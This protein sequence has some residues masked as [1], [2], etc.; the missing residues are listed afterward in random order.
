MVEK[1]NLSNRV[2]HRLEL[3]P[4]DHD[5]FHGDKD[6]SFLPENVPIDGR[7]IETSEFGYERR[8]HRRRAWK[9]IRP[10]GQS[11]ILSR[12]WDGYLRQMP[13]SLTPL[14]GNVDT[15][16]LF[17]L[18][19]AAR[20]NHVVEH[21]EVTTSRDNILSQTPR[22]QYFVHPHRHRYQFIQDPVFSEISPLLVY[23]T[24]ER[25]WAGA[26]PKAE[27]EVN[28]EIVSGVEPI[29]RR[30]LRVGELRFRHGRRP[31]HEESQLLESERLQEHKGR[32]LGTARKFGPARDIGNKL[33]ASLGL[34]PLPAIVGIVDG[35]PLQEERRNHRRGYMRGPE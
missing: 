3:F 19:V 33:H 22:Y 35:A 29:E 23:R 17:S 14:L 12:R 11:G 30:L 20:F 25:D 15:E 4:I 1:F 5:R 32:M 31:I 21:E 26:G 27:R 10:V 6:T 13:H 24:E 9:D 18:R 34:R 16:K 28:T 2:C 8:P 7:S